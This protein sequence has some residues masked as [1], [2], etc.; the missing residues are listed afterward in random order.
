MTELYIDI[1]KQE[2]KPALGCTEPIAV[3]LAVAKAC[4]VSTLEP[5]KVVVEVSANILKNGMGVGIPGTGMIGLD[6][7]AALS[8]VCGKSCY[9]LEVLKEVCPQSAQRAN[10][11]ITAGMIDIKLADTEE[12]LFIAAVAI[13]PEGETRVE[14]QERHD[15]IT[16]VT[17][18][19]KSIEQNQA[20]DQEGEAHSI[21]TRAAD[22]TVQKIFDFAMTVELE[23]IAFML[24]ARDLNMTLA[25][26][27]LSKS[28]GLQV[29]KML[30]DPKQKDIVG[31]S[32]MSYAMALTSAASDARMAGC[33]L[34]AMSN[35]GSGNQGITVTMPVVAT[36][37]KLGSNQEQLIRALALS[38][39]TAIHI[40]SHLGRLSALCGCV[41]A[42]SG[43][44][45]GIAYLLGGG[46]TEVCSALKNMMGNITGMVCDGAKVGC[47]L[48]VATGVSCAVQSTLLALEGV[49]ISS[50]DGIIDDS[51]EKT[52]INLGR[53]G[54]EGMSQTDKIMLD[55]M[56][57]KCN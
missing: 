35:S 44:A 6:I 5:T 43:A 36:A 22:M 49:C 56:V 53:I 10:E 13:S 37:Q 51:I 3:A 42:S 12:K 28:Y 45:C 54:S 27:G 26:E 34:P 9:G 47:A 16:S 33:V 8:V 17:I 41:V 46:Y 19:G 4:E 29:G 30:Y 52:I 7:A 38:H 32:L 31:D 40:K 55:I 11:L 24:E 39:L 57:E 50:N 1:L 20:T 15:N 14:I 48:K 21:D 25:N 18:N 2:V 23:R